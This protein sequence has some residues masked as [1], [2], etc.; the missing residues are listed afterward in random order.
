MA[1]PKDSGHF[2]VVAV[3]VGALPDRADVPACPTCQTTKFVTALVDM[4]DSITKGICC[5]NGHGLMPD[6]LIRIPLGEAR[7]AEGFMGLATNRAL[8]LWIKEFG[9]GLE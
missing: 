7:R 5:E 2:G 9:G 4:K 3:Y 8:D 6:D 1:A